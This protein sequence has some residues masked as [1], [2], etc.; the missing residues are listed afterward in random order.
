MEQSVL[1]KVAAGLARLTGVPAVRTIAIAAIV[2][3]W[4]LGFMIL[5]PGQSPQP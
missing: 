5:M 1:F 4:A 2:V 3:L